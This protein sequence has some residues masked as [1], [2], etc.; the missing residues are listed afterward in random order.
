MGAL[1]ISLKEVCCLQSLAASRVNVLGQPPVS[2]AAP[3]LQLGIHKC[4]MFKSSFNRPNL[5][6]SGGRDWPGR[7]SPDCVQ[8]F[9]TCCAQRV[10]DSGCWPPQQLKPSS[11][12]GSPLAATKCARRRRGAWRRLRNSSWRSS[13]PSRSQATSAPGACRWAV[14]GADGH[15]ASCPRCARPPRAVCRCLTAISVPSLACTGAQCG[16]VYCMAR[17]ECERVADELD[18]QLADMLGFALPGGRRRVK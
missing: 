18:G 1:R 12:A 3:L 11:R 10:G 5:R 6:Q 9:A 14:G 17:A 16:I 7:G 2:L 13:P 4:L 15:C 8:P